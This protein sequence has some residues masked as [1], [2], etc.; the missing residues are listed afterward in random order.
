MTINQMM[1]KEEESLMQ[2]VEIA[3]DDFI[4]TTSIRREQIP[5]AWLAWKDRDESR[6]EREG[7]IDR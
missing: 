1:E 3:T 7:E 4:I 2:F 6:D 5:L